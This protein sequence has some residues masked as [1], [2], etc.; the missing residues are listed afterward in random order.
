MRRFQC[1]LQGPLDYRRAR[2][3]SCQLVLARI[4]AAIGDEQRARD[5]ALRQAAGGAVARRENFRLRRRRYCELLGEAAA[6]EARLRRLRLEAAA[7]A[8][9]LRQAAGRRGAL[10]RLCLRQ[11][12]GH[13]LEMTRLDQSQHDEL[14]RIRYESG[15]RTRLRVARTRQEH[16]QS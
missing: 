2:E 5:R 6:H 8:E 15:R 3:R 7:A 4:V 14:A 10:E 12:A 13:A 9:D 1:S 11:R 16:E